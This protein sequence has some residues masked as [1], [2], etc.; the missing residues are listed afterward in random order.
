M[1]QFGILK[2]YILVISLEFFI[3]MVVPE[4]RWNAFF[5]LCIPPRPIEFLVELLLCYIII[6][7]AYIVANFM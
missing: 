1:V 4:E 3:L 5:V 2:D 7:V 6:F